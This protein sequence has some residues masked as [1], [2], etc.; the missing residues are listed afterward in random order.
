MAP[1]AATANDKEQGMMRRSLVPVVLV[2]AIL[3]LGLTGKAAAADDRV[4]IDLEKCYA[5]EVEGRKGLEGLARDVRASILEALPEEIKEWP[6]TA[7][8]EPVYGHVFIDYR[9]HHP[10]SGTRLHFIV[11]E[12]QGPDTGYDICYLDRNADM[13]LTNDTPIRALEEAPE[14]VVTG[15]GRGEKVY[16]ETFSMPVGDGADVDTI[17]LV[18]ELMIWD[19]EGTVYRNVGLLVRTLRTGQAIIAGKPYEVYLGFVSLLSSRYDTPWTALF[20]FRKGK[21]PEY[22]IYGHRLGAFREID[23]TLY[24]C[25]VTPSGSQLTVAPYDGEWGVLRMGAPQPGIKMKGMRGCLSSEETLVNLGEP[26][27]RD[28]VEQEYTIPVGDYLPLEL[29]LEYKNLTFEVSNNYYSDGCGELG[30]EKRRSEPT[31][32]GLH[33][34]ED[35]PLVLDFK[36]PLDVMFAWPAKEHRVRAGDELTVST[37]LREPKMDLMIRG[38]RFDRS[39]ALMPAVRVARANGEVVSEGPATYG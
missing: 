23:G 22:S 37:V 14:G 34:R 7:S 6:V 21:Q 39:Q 11:D 29:Y 5:S 27:N 24:A 2:W 28:R 3:L 4:V 35:A 9:V 18:P 19:Y 17:E 13:D 30:R 36:D 25:S 32:F 20:L 16:F 26:G 12:S 31:V 8:D 38:L 33:V 15:F 1:H 10:G